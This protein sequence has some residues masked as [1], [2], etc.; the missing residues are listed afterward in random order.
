MKKILIVLILMSSFLFAGSMTN[1]NVFTN[2]D[3]AN[4]AGAYLYGPNPAWLA[5]TD[6]DF[7]VVDR[8]D[9]WVHLRV[10]TLASTS[11]DFIVQCSTKDYVF[12][13]VYQRRFIAPGT[14]L[15]PVRERC[16]TMAIGSKCNFCILGDSI[17]AKLEIYR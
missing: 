11:I 6:N 3:I 10:T 7:L 1:I 13:T 5:P 17:S 16:Y 14:L 2:Y 4:G 15:I 9:T 12:S 8:I